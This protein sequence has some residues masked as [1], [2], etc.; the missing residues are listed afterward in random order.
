MN[1]IIHLPFLYPFFAVIWIGN[2][3][4]NIIENENYMKLWRIICAILFFP[5]SFAALI[6]IVPFVLI[7]VLFT[8]LWWLC[9]IIFKILQKRQ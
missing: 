8:P 6:F 3:F 7:L 1:E 5:V 2:Q 9:L 4:I